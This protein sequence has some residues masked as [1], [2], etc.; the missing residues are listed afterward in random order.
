[1]G[2]VMRCACFRVQGLWLRVEGLRCRVGGLGC[3]LSVGESTHRVVR[4]K[5]P[6]QPLACCIQNDPR[7]EED[8]SLRKGGGGGGYGRDVFMEVEGREGDIHT[9]D[10]ALEHGYSPLGGAFHDSSA[11]ACPRS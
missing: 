11:A 4:G 10:K 7:L 5:I 8:A 9:D 2:E 1:M 6:A 3:T